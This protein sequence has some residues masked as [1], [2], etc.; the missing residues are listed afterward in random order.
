MQTSQ[1]KKK[2]ANWTYWGG[3]MLLLL[4]WIYIQSQMSVNSD[5]AWLS[6]CAQR[7]LN[8]M[9]MTEG[10]YDTNPPLSVL[11]YAPFIWLSKL[12]SIASYHLIFWL[13][14]APIAFATYATYKLSQN[15][16]LT[17]SF[18]ATITIIPSLYYAE[19]DHFIAIMLMPFILVQFAITKE[20]T[21]N[22][23][24]KYSIL[25]LGSLALLLKPHF[26]LIPIFMLIHRMRYQRTFW[27]M[28]DT[29][30][31]ILAASCISYLMIIYLYYNDFLTQILP[32]V[33]EF[34]LGYNDPQ[35][36]IKKLTIYGSLWAIFCVSCSLLSK[37]Y[38]L[39]LLVPCA[40]LCLL[41]FTIQM[42]GFTYH[43]LP[44]FAL[45]FPL[46]F[47]N[48]AH[49]PKLNPPIILIAIFIFVYIFSPLRPEY[50]SH[51]DYKNNDITDYINANCN[52]PCSFYIMH[53][54]MDIVSQIAF[55]SGHTY[56]TRFP[57]FWFQPKI[58]EQERP[59]FAKYI[60]QDLEKFKPDL[61]LSLQT[62]KRPLDIFADNPALEKILN[63]YKKTD[64]L[65]VDR[66]FFYKDTKYEFTYEL[67]WD[68]Y[69]KHE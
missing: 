18:L 27:V 68:V 60:A 12:T 5:V 36:I 37:D 58:T 7:L 9:T 33:L 51:Q 19:R 22:A 15:I 66:A 21:L 16:V 31:I 48:L 13:T 38:R 61:I 39:K 30:F 62:E 29:D 47:T 41:V 40:G 52:Q 54:N 46:V 64:E 3:A 43:L 53:Q 23:T 65:T 63:Q 26:G 6:I 56:A 14:L 17:I 34:Y 35:T 28:K 49:L 25:I 4:P 1:Q 44:F 69:K 10:C 57:A 67:K 59:R 32:D 42:K 24:L 8:G 11:V 55:Y 20:E 45:F 50:P 2:Q